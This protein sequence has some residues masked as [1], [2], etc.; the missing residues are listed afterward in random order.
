MTA[1]VVT[2][3]VNSLWQVPLLGLCAWLALRLARPGAGVRYAV[4][5]GALLV[6]VVLPLRGVEWRSGGG[7]EISATEYAGALPVMPVTRRYVPFMAVKIS[8]RCANLLAVLYVGLTAACVLR[9]VRAQTAVRRLRRE[10][11]AWGADEGG[12]RL[13]AGEERTPLVVGVLRPVILLP[14]WMREVSAAELATVLAHERAHIRRQDLAMNLALR[15]LA[16][17]VGYHPATTWMQRR[18]RQTRE[19]LVDA[20]AARAVGSAGT[21]AAALLG[22]ADHMIAE[23]P[24]AGAGLGAMLLEESSQ[25]QLEERL[26]NLIQPSIACHPVARVS[27]VVAGCAVL[28]SAAALATVVHV[29]PRVL[30]A[31]SEGAVAVSPQPGAQVTTAEGAKPSAKILGS[32]SF[33]MK[34]PV[35]APHPAVFLMTTPAQG[36]T[37]PHVRVVVPDVELH[38]LDTEAEARIRKLSAE[39]AQSQVNSPEFK[40]A[41]EEMRQKL[42]SPEFKKQIKEMSEQARKMAMTSEAQRKMSAEIERQ[43]N[44]PEFRRQIEQIRVDTAKIEKEIAEAHL[45]QLSVHAAELA[46]AGV[47]AQTDAPKRVSAAVMAGQRLSGEQPVYPPDAKASHIEGVVILHA[48]IGTDGA[49]DSLQLVSGPEQLTKAAWNAVKTWVYKPYL[50]N[51]VPTAVDTTITVTFSFGG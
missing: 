24:E 27:R 47:A 2:Y 39:I 29:S 30:A 11:T 22:L 51:G 48:V 28:L 41:M 5:I 6:S 16:L 1:A 18:V 9:L 4:W 35:D 46:A 25:N 43:V 32:D 44:S 23:A 26:M 50:L 10:S 31:Q 17:P 21:Y 40:R 7:V 13:L 3:F 14:A 38:P 36:E 33:V 34:T 42:D 12:V 8:S 45:D 37:D 19:L 20:E 15:V 49:I